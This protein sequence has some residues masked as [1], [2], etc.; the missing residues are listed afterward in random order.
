MSAVGLG[1]R[2][3]YTKSF[4]G[5]STWMQSAE[6]REPRTAG[7][8]ESLPLRYLD[9]LFDAGLPANAGELASAAAKDHW[10]V[11]VSGVAFIRVSRALV[12]FRKQRPPRPRSPLP[13][14]VLAAIVE[15][16]MAWGR[17][18][19]ALMLTLMYL[20]CSRTGE[21]QKRQLPRPIRSM[22]PSA[23]TP[24]SLRLRRIRS[25]RVSV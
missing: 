2:K 22:R 9:F 17:R 25:R 16:M 6:L 4:A 15:M 10:A 23:G 14:E 21:M 5:L 24:S 3:S 11:L 18:D 19:M 20:M 7:E 8:L 13:K 12:G 1:V